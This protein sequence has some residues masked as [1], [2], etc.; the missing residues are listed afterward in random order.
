L[1]QCIQWLEEHLQESM[2]SKP[3]SFDVFCQNKLKEFH[4]CVTIQLS[5]SISLKAKLQKLVDLIIN[6][7]VSDCRGNTTF[8]SR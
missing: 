3:T 4:E 7:H 1:D 8:L 6:L 5:R 2:A